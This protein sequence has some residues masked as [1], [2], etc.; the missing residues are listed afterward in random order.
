MTEP[1]E[2]YYT[3]KPVT[4]EREFDTWFRSDDRS[5]Q[6]N[7]RFLFYPHLHGDTRQEENRDDSKPVMSGVLND[8][9][10]GDVQRKSLLI[11]NAFIQG[12]IWFNRL[13]PALEIGPAALK[14]ALLL[15]YKKSLIKSNTVNLSKDEKQSMG[16]DRSSV[17]RSLDELERIGLV[18]LERRNGASTRITLLDW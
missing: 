11:K 16:L 4:R 10:N 2:N 5:N 12:P 7:Q 9:L 17:K 8:D 13:I 18:R 14:V 3:A 1:I 15:Y 6:K